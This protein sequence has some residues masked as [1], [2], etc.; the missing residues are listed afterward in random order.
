MS[1]GHEMAGPIVR[2]AAGEQILEPGEHPRNRIGDPPAVKE[3]FEI[4]PL[5]ANL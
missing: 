2:V 5:P 3:A 4:H 1:V